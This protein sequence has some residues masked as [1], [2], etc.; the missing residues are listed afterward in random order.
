MGYTCKH[1]AKDIFPRFFKQT[2]AI[3]LCPTPQSRVP[4]QHIWSSFLM[5][6][7]VQRWN[8]L[9]RDVVDSS[10]LE[11]FKQW[12][13]KYLLEMFDEDFLLQAGGWTK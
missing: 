6:K 11:I 7:V 2:F 9:P 10:S 5:V 12:L 13:D 3:H 1:R 4:E 8:R